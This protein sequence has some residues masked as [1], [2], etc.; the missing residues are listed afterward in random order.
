MRT[1]KIIGKVFFAVMVVCA[2]MFHSCD[3]FS[4]DVRKTWDAS[5]ISNITHGGTFIGYAR[6]YTIDWVENTSSRSSEKYRV[7]KKSNGE[8]IIDYKGEICILQKA[9]KPFGQGTYALKWMIDYKHYIEDIPTS[10]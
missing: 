9:D 5:P 10:Y 6:V 7:Y 8:Y 3:N 1:E 4:R 2:M